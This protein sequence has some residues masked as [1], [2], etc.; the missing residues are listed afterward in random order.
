MDSRSYIYTEDIRPI[1][2]IEFGILG[3]NEVKRI[4]ALDPIGIDIPDLYDNSEP[5]EGGLIDPKLGTTDPTIDCSTCGLNYT[6]CVGHFGHIVL[7]TPAYHTE[8]IDYVKKILSVICLKCCKILINKNE[9]ELINMLKSKTQKGRWN[10]IKKITSKVTYCK[11][12]GNPVSKIKK[13]KR[14]QTASIN[15]IA[16][17]NLSNMQ[18]E[19][20]DNKIKKNKIRQ[21]ITPDMCYDILRNISDRDC[22]IIGL[23]PSR[24]RPEDMIL[25]IFPVPPIA[26]RPSVKASYMA[27][28]SAEDD[29][30]VKLVGIIKYNINVRKYGNTTNDASNHDLHSHLLQYNI[31]T[32]FN[33][34]NVSIPKAE[35]RGK[36]TKSLSSRLKGKPGRI[37]GNL[38]GK[39]VDFSGRTV[40]TA[41]PDIEINQL[42]VPIKIAMNLTIPET[43][44]PENILRLTKLVRN[45]RDKYP[46]ANFVIPLSKYTNRVYQIDLRYSK[47]TIELNFGDIVERHLID[48]DF[49]LLNRQPTLHKISMM[50]HFIKVI[51][52]ENLST[53]RLSVL[54]TT[55]YNADFDGDEMNIFV[56]QSVQSMLELSEIANVKYQFISPKTGDPIIGANQDSVTGSYNLTNSDT[57]IDWKEAMNILSY[58]KVSDLD[59][60]KKNKNYTGQEVFSMIIPE[61]ITSSEGGIKIENGNM[62]SGQLTKSSV[63]GRNSISHYI[64]DEYGPDETKNFL[65]NLAR[66]TNNFN[67]YRGFTV[68]IG[69]GIIDPK[70]KDELEKLYESKRIEIDHLIT[71]MENNTNIIDQQ[72]FEEFI[73]ADLQNILPTTATMVMNNLDPSNNF[74]IMIKSGAK[75]SE[76]NPAQISGS[77]GQ[78]NVENNRIKKKVNNRCLPYF[79]QHDDSMMGRGF[80]RNSFLKGAT[81]T[82]FIFHN[83][84]SREGLIDTA[85]KTAESGYLQRKLIKALEDIMVKY[86]N[87]VRTATNNLLQFVYGDDCIDPTKQYQNNLE[88]ILLG[89]TE[90][91][92]KYGYTKE[93]LNKISDKSYTEEL[94]NKHIRSILKL[95]NLVRLSRLRLSNNNMAINTNFSLPVN[96]KRLLA[97]ID[98]NKSGD[99]KPSYVLNKIK[100]ILNYSNT[101]TISMSA[102]DSTNKK[103]IKYKDDKIV[104]S[105][106]KLALYQWL[107]P[108]IICPLLSMENFDQLCVKIIDNYNRAIIEPGEMIGAITAQS[109]GEGTTQLTL[110]TF[111]HAGIGG[112]GSATLGVPRLKEIF[113]FSKDIKTPVM[114]LYLETKYK[115]NTDVAN[116]IASHIKTTILGNM[117]DGLSVIYDPNHE[118]LEAD[119]MTK[120]MFKKN[121]SKTSCQPDLNN[122]NW[123]IR[124]ELNKEKLLLSGV[125]LL[126]IK[127]K[128]CDMWERRFK[129]SKGVKSEKKQLLEKIIGCAILSNHENDHQPIIHI[130]IEISNV[131]LNTILS[132]INFYVDPLKLRGITG[133]TKDPSVDSNQRYVSFD[134]KNEQVIYGNETVI[135]INGVNMEDIR[136]INGVDLYTT[137]TND[138]VTVY[139]L[140]GIEAARI[141]IIKEVSKVFGDVNYQH[142]A[143]LADYMTWPGILT[144]IDRHALSKLDTEPLPRAS[145]EKTVEQL[146]QAAV[147]GETDHMNSVSS[148]VMGGL[149]MRGGTGLCNIILDDELLE[150]SEYYE[151][152][153]MMF[154]DSISFNDV[155]TN[156]MIDDITKNVDDDNCDIFIP[157]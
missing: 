86:D 102:E 87:S 50:G 63:R 106:F 125:K 73:K 151:E 154:G 79:F 89:N 7:S 41:G 64:W 122:L 2:R 47:D 91:K 55:P 130:K 22:E 37:R 14:Q 85:I 29:L 66:L 53:F 49:V 131:S 74:K 58:T 90:I 142:I 75:G 100:D 83:I 34:D 117:I 119:K 4:S 26:I 11:T 69:D 51:E 12:C 155:T 57:V 9:E 123:L 60:I 128:F 18:Q 114:T 42:G 139:K 81:P 54:V 25:K 118:Y 101:K 13:E 80:I 148:R 113:S 6:D 35:I 143:L 17:I 72:V 124:I 16:E 71:D 147:F 20:G 32:Y 8:F 56:P 137:I 133:I 157:E 44:T 109:M 135:Y 126:D 96:F 27:S 94:N 31:T 136:Y 52:D 116:K 103:S 33:N 92:E 95:R 132:F 145:F 45:G 23:D 84:G 77:I 36:I 70:V 156:T 134:S 62:L 19:E 121:Y 24:S 67:L 59:K 150:N 1:D 28:G 111:H 10:E 99:L 107:S 144:S 61:K 21:I 127:S 76:T 112:K 97:S 98:K 146:I 108:K 15:L 78:Q 40:I 82:E 120:P 5:K 105:T 141:A 3:N 93:E 48:G 38:M 39:R 153:E 46:G 138:I 30:T 129:E 140:F 110:N 68:G 65:D 104:K 43:V 149:V 152:G 88:I 115:E